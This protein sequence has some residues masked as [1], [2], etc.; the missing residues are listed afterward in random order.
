MKK[1]EAELFNDHFQNFKKYGL[2]K[3]QLVIADIPYNIGVNA[4]GSNPNWY[5][6]G[7]NK[8]GES[9]FAGKEFFDTDK[10]FKPAEF[11]HFC[12][13]MMKKEPK[14]KGKAP[15][16]LVF[17]AFDQQMYLI[18]LAKRYGI[19]NYINLVFRKN[20]SAQV[21]KA[22][23]RI[24][25]NCEYGLLLYRDKLPKFNNNG[26][27]VFNCI[28]WER[29]NVTPKIHPTQKPVPLLRKLIE[30]FT[31]EGDIVIDPCA[32]SGTTIIASIQ[33][34]RK[35]YGF[36]IKKEMFTKAKALIDNE[37]EIQSFG[38]N[39]SDLKKDIESCFFDINF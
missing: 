11:M 23:M 2:H 35:G 12:S 27:M 4:Y 32:G 25:G 15:A 22:N 24:V 3:A 7:D 1:V 31:D 9:E 34:N 18:E 29:D 39:K 16:M 33:T 14:E 37:K 30:I 6:D 10:N 20:F 17:C 13:K 28:D 38:Y 36:E 5:V 21:L 8:N 26:K 19:N